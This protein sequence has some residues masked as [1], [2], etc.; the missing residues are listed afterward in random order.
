[1]KNIILA[2]GSGSRLFPLSRDLF[3]K[4][5][6]QALNG[7]SFL[8]ETLLRLHGNT[9]IVTSAQTAHLCRVQA[10]QCSGYTIDILSEPSAKDTG[11]AIVYAL[12]LFN[13]DDIIGVFP[14]DHDIKD[15]LQ[16]DSL[17]SKAQAVA[18]SGYI[19]TL[20]IAPA[21]PE[22]GFGYI[23][24][25][26]ALQ[27][28]SFKVL[29]FVEK[30][31]KATAEQYLGNG[32]YLWNAGMYIFKKS[33]MVHEIKKHA[34]SLFTLY[35]GLSEHNADVK[36]LYNTARSESIDTAVIEKTDVVAVIPADP[37]WS[38]AGSWKAYRDIQ[39][40]IKG[41]QQCRDVI[42]INSAGCM[43]SA[44]KK[45][46]ALANVSDLA[47]I[48]TDDVLLVADL[49]HSQDVKKIYDAVKKTYPETVK[50]HVWEQRPWGIFKTIDQGDGYKVKKITVFAGQQLSLQ[51]HN[52]RCE[53]WTMISGKGI[54]TLGEK[55]FPVKS[56]DTVFV[57]LGEKHTIQA[58]DQLEFI[59]VQRG[60]YLGE[61]DI[62]RL[63]DHYG[64]V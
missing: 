39:P 32:G 12:T 27:H 17:L 55:E 7:N 8:Q 58:V 20:G 53:Y 25:G 54:M 64:R 41:T 3:P 15:K 31:D 40:D 56:G 46:V 5:F 9:I 51:Y 50:S 4:Q 45:I 49:A 38:D 33:V 52:H 42:S 21:Y 60:D 1:M 35:C 28:G 59:E 6:I 14:S 47:I 36:Q 24:Q 18:E 2:G 34:P 57:P 10:E 29:R 23:Q 61:D 26:E 48:D 22:T 13:D 16:F 19:V 44:P 63:A 30:P 37:G 62:V 43:V 11:P